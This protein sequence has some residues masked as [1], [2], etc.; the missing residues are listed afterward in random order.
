MCA[1]IAGRSPWWHCAHRVIALGFAL[2][3]RICQAHCKSG[4][5][6]MACTS[7]RLRD[8]LVHFLSKTCGSDPMGVPSTV[9]PL[10]CHFGRQVR[11][12]IGWNPASQVGRATPSLL[13]VRT[14]GKRH[15]GMRTI[16]RP[17]AMLSPLPR[18]LPKS[19]WRTQ[20][21][22]VGPLVLHPQP[23]SHGARPFHRTTGKWKAGHATSALWHR[24]KSPQHGGPQDVIV[25][26][27]AVGKNRQ[28]GVGIGGGPEHVPDA[29]GASS[30][31]Q[32]KLE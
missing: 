17:A 28:T 9:M 32:D 2:W 24:V 4:T 15:P 11:D 26:S 23:A 21:A 8:A 31:G 25:G 12:V 14:R 13:K 20:A 30:G 7:P 6:G 22:L 1:A 27:D 16:V 3:R 29:V 5:V 10:D 19:R 18:A